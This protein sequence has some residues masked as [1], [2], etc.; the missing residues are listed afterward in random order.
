MS[1]NKITGGIIKRIAST[2]LKTLFGSPIA[3]FI[4]TVFSVLTAIDLTGQFS[5][6]VGFYDMGQIN[7][8]IT[9][10]IFLGD[11][12]FLNK[13]VGKLF[14]Y[15]PLLTMGLFSRESASGSIKLAYSSPVT[16]LQLVLGKFLAA[17][18]V[19]ACLLVIPLLAT[20]TGLIT[21]EHFDLLAVLVAL[22]GL[23]LLI[24]VYC[25]IGLLMSS[26]TSYQVVAAVATLAALAFC[27]SVGKL[28]K[29]YEAIR[30][31]TYWLS[32]SGRV[33]SFLKGV[34]RSDDLIYFL[35]MTMMMVSLTVF[36]VSF[37]RMNLSF[38]KKA[39]AY[40]SLL[41][42]VALLAWGSSRPGT[43]VFA[44]ATATKSN[45]ITKESRDVVAGIPGKITITNYVNL[46]DKLSGPYLPTQ[47][48]P[49]R[50][51]FEQ[52]KLV[53]PDIEEH[54]VYYSSLVPDVTQ[55][56][57]FA[58]MTEDELKNFYFMMYDVNPSVFKS[59][60]QVQ[61]IQ[62][63]K[64]EGY[65]FVREI[66]TADGKSVALR[67]YHD[68]ICR[69]TEPEI[70]AAFAKLYA[71]MPSVAFL[72]EEGERSITSGDKSGYGAF[73]CQKYSR[74]ALMNQGFDI[75]QV[76]AQAA[77]ADSL[78]ILVVADPVREF[79]P[80]ALENLKKYLDRGSNMM[81]LA[82]YG[83]QSV[84]NPLLK[85]VGLKVSDCQIAAREG[86]MSASLI[87]ARG[88]EEAEAFKA[89]CRKDGVVTMPGCLAIETLEDN[90]GFERK[91]ILRTI[92]GAWLEKDYAGFRDDE[93]SLSADEV[94]GSFVT[95]YALSREIGGREQR[96]VV[97]GDADCLSDA[98][99]GVGREDVDAYNQTLITRSFKW[100]SDGQFPVDVIREPAR[101]MSFRI[102]TTG[103]DLI[104]V[105]FLYLIP[106]LILAAGAFVLMRRRRA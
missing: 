71:R 51:E 67:N 15:I 12:G 20:L 36:R 90:A 27:G 31:I 65:N 13:I 76:S 10:S 5:S 28:G 55:N 14:I 82:D 17:L 40:A 7:S 69:P 93:V 100:L 77:I 88:V 35:T 18:A 19:G 99:M 56:K 72:Q 103:A 53:K 6:Y 61:D 91:A 74:G 52:Y 47:Y 34:L 98:E 57:R 102:H 26:L 85:M 33:E 105:I 70:T 11:Y 104:K 96:I 3:W 94:S 60:E 63:I 37:P 92:P 58:G 46:F 24:A 2:E 42:C 54:T 83:H 86:D 39:G 87:L 23:F 49:M 66:K 59:S 22:L 1:S 68:M 97:V 73:T 32:M 75:Y 89:L 25:S 79:T 64:D 81:I 62:I 43:L 44:D 4:L 41:V 106:A 84:V 38:W 29:E 21:I 30:S 78:N 101:D 45:S 8:S 16:S 48:N 50:S 80:E 95:A 9:G